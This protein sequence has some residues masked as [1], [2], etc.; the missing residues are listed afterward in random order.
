[1]KV[2]DTA[3]LKFNF[4]KIIAIQDDKITCEMKDWSGENSVTFELPRSTIRS[5]DAEESWKKI[6]EDARKAKMKIEHIS[7]DLGGVYFDKNPATYVF[8]GINFLNVHITT[9]KAEIPTRR[10]YSFFAFGI[11]YDRDNKLLFSICLC[12]KPFYCGLT[13]KSSKL[14]KILKQYFKIM[15][16]NITF[17]RL[18][19]AMGYLI[20]KVESLE[21]VLLQMKH[22]P[23]LP[24][25]RWLNLDE[26]IDYL[27]DHPAKA[28]ACGWVSNR[29]I[30]YHKG[31]RKLRFL[32]SE[33]DSWLSEGKRKSESEMEAEAQ[34]YL[35]KRGEHPLPVYMETFS[36]DLNE[37]L[38][39]FVYHIYH[40]VLNNP[41]PD[42]ELDERNFGYNLRS[43]LTDNWLIQL[44][45]FSLLARIESKISRN[46]LKWI[47][48][49]KSGTEVTESEVKNFVAS[50]LEEIMKSDY[51][52]WDK[53]IKDD[54]IPWR[55]C[56]LK[57]EEE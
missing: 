19:E 9:R 18:P 49:K 39:K 36:E 16:K 51:D 12:S 8:V 22:E 30:P 2:G 31:G 40:C 13:L 34:K 3:T 48:L 26:L 50:Q 46:V 24:A 44:A 32:K 42:Y 41:D 5:F 57:K 54:M 15:D 45:D 37:I 43:C 10:R 55:N 6:I 11:R 29:Q 27:P 33:I 25:D 47:N 1:M 4:A 23:E 28:T 53:C 7:I 52:L 21:Q 17:D 38:D 56:G 35:T 20:G 14:S